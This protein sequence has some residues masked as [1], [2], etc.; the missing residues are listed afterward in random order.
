MWNGVGVKS[1]EYGGAMKTKQ[2]DC[3]AR[4]IYKIE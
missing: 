2:T 4:G 1:E 3:C